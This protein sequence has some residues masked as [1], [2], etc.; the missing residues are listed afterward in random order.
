[1]EIVV[2]SEAPR[3]NSHHTKRH[4]GIEQPATYSIENPGSDSE[5]KAKAKADEQKSVKCGRS[6]GI[7]RI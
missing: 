5:G 2:N 6:S 3:S 7:Y 1:M 4:C